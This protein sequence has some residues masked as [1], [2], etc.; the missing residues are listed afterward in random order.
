MNKTI[1]NQIVL[2]LSLLVICSSCY[3]DKGN[4]VYKELVKL[5]IDTVGKGI[6][7]EMTALQFENFK[8]PVNI[9]YDG[10]IKNLSFEWKIY[11]Q[12]P[13]KEESA[14]KFDAPLVLSTKA[15]LDNIIYVTPDKYF[16][17]LTVT[18]KLQDIKHFLR[19][20]LNVDTRLSKGICVL[21]EKNGKYDLSMIR[22]SRLLTDMNPSD[23][24][25][26]RSIFSGVNSREVADGRFLGYA[27]AINTLYF[28]T[29]TGGFKL[30]ANTFKIV[31]DD[32]TSWFSF[33]IS[34][35]GTPEAFMQTSRPMQMLIDN[36][37][38]Y[39]WDHKSM[40]TITFGDRLN[41]DYHA[42][43][44]LPRISTSTF[45]TV[46]FDEKNNRFASI[47]QFG[48][49]VGVFPATPDA[50]FNLNDIG[51]S[52]QLMFMDNGFN[53]YTYAVF[54][55]TQTLNYDLYVADFSGTKATP[56]AKYK[57]DNC[58]EINKNTHYAFANRGNICFYASATKLY[59]YKYA[60]TNMAE[61]VH[62]FIG[63]TITGLKVFKQPQHAK[64][65]KLL[66]VSTLT[67]NGTGKL[68]LI[69]FN[70]LNGTIAGGTQQ[71]FEGFGKIVDI[72][73]K[74]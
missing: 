37:L 65:G 35:N 7:P 61:T 24:K 4:Y 9:K 45:S 14:K 15:A 8:V 60:S 52:K 17:T 19:I 55:D 34:I 66:I 23:D 54:H 38:V 67:K 6:S 70:E 25:V 30:N 50:V 1:K 39:V 42:A 43:S 18:D 40:G 58:P 46:I 63:E 53:E 21:D 68:Y 48:S 27:S 71:A 64:D 57:M 74:E 26:Y 59:Q 29:K 49:N 13:Q 5:E 33:P 10:D 2:L 73:I 69:E 36:G 12:N 47:N 62:S 51:K 31:S 22:T 44:Y 11:P 20:K 72:L 28:F 56:V 32:Y 16:L 3:D 41:G